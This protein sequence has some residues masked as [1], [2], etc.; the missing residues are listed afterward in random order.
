[1]KGDKCKLCKK[2]KVSLPKGL[3]CSVCKSKQKKERR[4]KMTPKQYKRE[5]ERNKRWCELNKGRRR[6][7]AR[8]SYHRNKKKNKKHV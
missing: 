7:I 4:A 2:E 5:Q 3:I 6:E 1:M 8:Q